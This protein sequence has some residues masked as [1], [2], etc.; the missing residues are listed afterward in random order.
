MVVCCLS[1]CH[2]CTRITTSSCRS[3]MLATQLVLI[4]ACRLM[5][6]PGWFQQ[7]AAEQQYLT[8]TAAHCSNHCYRCRNPVL[9]ACLALEPPP[10]HTHTPT[11]TPRCLTLLSSVRQSTCV[12]GTPPPVTSAFL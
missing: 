9:S 10:P 5:Y 2:E 7:G 4:P 6:L 11:P 12:R 1:T 8:C 3:S